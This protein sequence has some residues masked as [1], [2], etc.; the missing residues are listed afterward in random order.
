MVLSEDESGDGISAIDDD[1]KIRLA[2]ESLTGARQFG[3]VIVRDAEAGCF[4]PGVTRTAFDRD[5]HEF[6]RMG[7]SLGRKD[8]VL[9]SRL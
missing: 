7:Q 3:Q 8:V 2:G 6:L 5:S 9:P 1:G 4:F